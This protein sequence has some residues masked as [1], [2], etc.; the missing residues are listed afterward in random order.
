M[1]ASV[2]GCSQKPPK[3]LLGRVVAT[4]KALV[5]VSSSE[6]LAGLARHAQGDWGDLDGEDQKTNE[7]ALKSGG[8]LLSSY[9]SSRNIV[10]WIITEWDRSVTTVLL[11]EDY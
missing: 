2:G 7:L 11:P 10:F 6:I 1:C 8:R 9:R 4:P 5:A 3:F